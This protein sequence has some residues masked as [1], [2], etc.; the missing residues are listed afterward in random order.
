[1]AGF[2]IN[3]TFR[4]GDK[5]GMSKRLARTLFVYFLK[6]TGIFDLTPARKDYKIFCKGVVTMDALQKFIRIGDDRINVEE[7]ISYGIGIDEDEDRYL[8]VNTK[9]DEDIWQFYEEDVDFDLE[10]KLGE[11]D[12]MFL[13]K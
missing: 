7:I 6:V 4:R 11:L 10:E 13:I 8:Y 5:I 1:M 12:K 3:K 9:S 2:F